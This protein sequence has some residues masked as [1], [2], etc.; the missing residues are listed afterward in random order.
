M[1]LERNE[2]EG[3]LI[4]ALGSAQDTINALTNELEE[5]RRSIMN[6]SAKRENPCADIAKNNLPWPAWFGT[7]GNGDGRASGGYG[8]GHPNDYPH[9]SAS[10]GGHGSGGSGPDLSEGGGGRGPDLSEGG[11]GSGGDT[12]EVFLNAPAAGGSLKD[13]MFSID[14]IPDDE[15]CR[16]L[17][18]LV[19]TLH[20][21]AKQSHATDEKGAEQL[22][23]YMK[24][25]T[26][27]RKLAGLIDAR[28]R[29]LLRSLAHEKRWRDQFEEGYN[30]FRKRL[31]DLDN[32]LLELEEGNH[33]PGIHAA[34][35]SA[36]YKLLEALAD[37]DDLRK[38]GVGK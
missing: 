11:G 14:N 28:E 34:R 22:D 7:G 38:P 24:L 32:H 21:F 35:Q 1:T 26:S 25:V 5:A 15:L 10:P 29:G 20:T 2:Y 19:T 18:S 27:I 17:L 16:A 33:N 37:I 23:A 13:K 4:Q 30:G 36:E 6:L 31:L 12:V 9:T 8:A 3:D